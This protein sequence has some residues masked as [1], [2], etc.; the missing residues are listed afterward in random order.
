MLLLIGSSNEEKHAVEKEKFLK[1][2]SSPFGEHQNLGVF[3]LQLVFWYEKGLSV[4]PIR[5]IVLIFWKYLLF[6]LGNFEDMERIKQEKRKEHGLNEWKE[7]KNTPPPPCPELQPQF[8]DKIKLIEENDLMDDAASTATLDGQ[9]SKRLPWKPK[10][11]Q[12]DIELYLSTCR[13]KFLGYQLEGDTTSLVGLP[14][15][16]QEGV[17]ILRQHLYVSLGDVAMQHHEKMLETAKRNRKKLLFHPPTEKLYQSMLPI[18]EDSCITLLK[19]LL[20]SATNQ[21]VNKG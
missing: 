15:S 21:L 19:V 9:T 17:E 1:E 11:R 6:T 10:A 8:P 3:M 4:L 7:P 14:N 13:Q 12:Q 2:I 16:I 5:K 20:A 18:I